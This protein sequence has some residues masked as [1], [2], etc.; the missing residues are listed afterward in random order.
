MARRR[1]LP[2]PSDPDSLFSWYVNYR[3]RAGWGLLLL[4]LLSDVA[5][6]DAPTRILEGSHLAMPSLLEPFGEEGAG[7]AVCLCRGWQ[8]RPD[9]L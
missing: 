2:G 1:E 7:P 9:Q 8:T 3:S 4:C 6:D 5:S